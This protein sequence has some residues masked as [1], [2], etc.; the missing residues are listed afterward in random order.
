M[1]PLP[2]ILQVLQDNLAFGLFGN[3]AEKVK[4]SLSDLKCKLESVAL[5]QG[6]SFTSYIDWPGGVGKLVVEGLIVVGSG[7]VLPYSLTDSF[8]Q[9]LSVGIPGYFPV[10]VDGS[11]DFTL[12]KSRLALIFQA[13]SN[14]GDSLSLSSLLIY[15]IK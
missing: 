13:G 2:V 10:I 12:P 3:L 11:W 15:R 4:I 6:S 8:G 1:A 7:S 5:L 14:P 9:G